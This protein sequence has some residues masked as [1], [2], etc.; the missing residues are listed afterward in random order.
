MTYAV[1]QSA[2]FL[3]DLDEFLEYLA[4]YDED[5]AHEQLLR[6]RRIFPSTSPS[7]LALR[8]AF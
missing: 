6:L 7:A 5:Y 1:F 8:A 2:R 3:R 4:A